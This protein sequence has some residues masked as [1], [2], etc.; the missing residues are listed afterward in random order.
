M[1]TKKKKPEIKVS[2]DLQ[3]REY[4][5]NGVYGGFT[6]DGNFRMLLYNQQTMPTSDFKSFFIERSLKCNLVMS[7]VTLKTIL[8]WMQEHLKKFEEKFGEIKL[9]EEKGESKE[10]Y[11]D[12]D[13]SVR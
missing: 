1:S 3:Y 4:V 11:L 5:V 6:G 7:P 13:P 8:L 9:V 10:E 2:R 12:S